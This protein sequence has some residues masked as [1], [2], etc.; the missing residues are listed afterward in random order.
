M[1]NCLLRGILFFILNLGLLIA[2]LFFF[3]VQ[4]FKISSLQQ[5]GIS[6]LLSLFRIILQPCISQQLDILFKLKIIQEK[7]IEKIAKFFFLENSILIARFF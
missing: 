1:K 7:K 3:F 5:I 6:I 2:L 4:W